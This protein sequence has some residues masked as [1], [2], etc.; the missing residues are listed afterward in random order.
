MSSKKWKVDMRDIRNMLALVAK[1]QYSAREIAESLGISHQSVLRHLAKLEDAGISVSQACE[2]D[3]QQLEA[4]CYP[5]SPGPKSN[6]KVMPDLDA[7]IAELAKPNPPTRKVLFD[8]YCDK[9][10]ERAYGYSQFCEF[11]RQGR[12]DTSLTMHIEH[13]PGDRLLIDFAGDKVGIYSSPGASEPD[14]TASIFVATLA[15]SGKTFTCATRYQDVASVIDATERAFYFFG[16]S[17]SRLVPDNMAA[18]VVTAKGPKKALKLNSSFCEFAN[19]YGVLIAPTRVRKPR[20]YP[21]VL[22]IP[23]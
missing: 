7:I 11:V 6:E 13:I 20:D 10:Q 22:V 18:A 17:V 19:H 21:E 9:Y 14:Y 3:D 1:D 15:F 12:K 2:L 8:E 16:G 5:T 4:I 23:N